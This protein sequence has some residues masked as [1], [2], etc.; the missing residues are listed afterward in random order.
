MS[1]FEQ[2]E[3]EQGIWLNS[4]MR[5]AGAAFGTSTSQWLRQFAAG[6]PNLSMAVRIDC[7]Q[8]GVLRRLLS[9]SGPSQL[10]NKLDALTKVLPDGSAPADFPG[11]QIRAV[12]AP[13]GSRP[14]FV[15]PFRVWPNLDWLLLESQ[16]EGVDFSWQAHICWLDAQPPSAVASA[17]NLL[18]MREAL[19]PE[20]LLSLQT[21][22][23]ERLRKPCFNLE[24]YV[25]VR[26]PAEEK[27]LQEALTRIFRIQFGRLG[28]GPQ[29]FQPHVDAWSDFIQSGIH[30]HTT[31]NPEPSELCSTAVDQPEIETLLRSLPGEEKGRVLTGR[32]LAAGSAQHLPEPA[33]TAGPFAFISYAHRDSEQIA[34]LL[35]SIAARSIPCWYD[36]GLQ[37]GL[38]WQRQL[39]DRIQR[40]SVFLVFLSQSAMDSSYVHDEIYF[41]RKYGKPI[42]PVTMGQ[43]EWHCGIEMVLSPYQMLDFHKGDL[44]NELARTLQLQL[45]S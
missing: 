4:E 42:L 8:G 27:W 15:P 22:L 44:E 29:T 36:T 10:S 12:G 19:V 11:K 33:S 39:A 34:M 5:P 20:A 32:P 3:T 1:G 26:K 13:Q 38:D 28:F 21:G 24:E 17:R 7:S 9:F 23:A 16:R 6:E 2:I 43:L 30:S 14:W 37:A 41:A 40:C 18:D 25:G 45:V 31:Y 35:K